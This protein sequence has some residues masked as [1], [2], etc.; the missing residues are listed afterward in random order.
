MYGLMEHIK[1]GTTFG[2]LFRVL[3]FSSHSCHI[4]VVTNF[5]RF[6]H[7]I[8]LNS[9]FIDHQLVMFKAPPNDD[10]SVRSVSRESEEM[11]TQHMT[12]FQRLGLT[13]DQQTLT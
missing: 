13:C 7:S 10:L 9:I 4:D 3:L 1:L 11:D 5:G 8:S 6:S 2:G 12:P